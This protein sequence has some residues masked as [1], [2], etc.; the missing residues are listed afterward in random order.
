V[1]KKEKISATRIKFWKK[2]GKKGVLIYFD[3]GPEEEMIPQRMKWPD[4]I[5]EGEDI[6]SW[7]RDGKELF[8]VYDR[9]GAYSYFDMH[10]HKIPFQPLGQKLERLVEEALNKIIK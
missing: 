7:G 6:T 8:Y 4:Y 2:Y 3:I 5:L 1:G 9:T 10:N